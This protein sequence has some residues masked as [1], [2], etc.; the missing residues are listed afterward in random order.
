V[1]GHK[2]HCVFLWG[3][4]GGGRPPRP[5][6]PPPPTTHHLEAKNVI[7]PR[8]H[9]ATYEYSHFNSVILTRNK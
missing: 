3:G 6:P 5:P 4:G 1:G 7:L 8:H 2:K 9:I